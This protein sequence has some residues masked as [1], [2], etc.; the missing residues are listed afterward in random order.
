[1]ARKKQLTVPYRRKGSGNTNYKKRRLLLLAGKPRLVIR[2]SLKNVMCVVA[3]YSAEGDKMM[4]STHSR[5]LKK[6]GWQL[7]ANNTSGAYLTGLLMGVKIKGKKLENLVVDLGLHPCIKGSKITAVIK[8]IVD[9]GI[10]L[11]V[12]KEIL[13]PEERIKGEHI[14]RFAE[15]LKKD[16][17]MYNKQFSDYIKKN[18][19]PVNITTY[20]EQTKNKIMKGTQNA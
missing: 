15:S 5:E 8:G 3:E 18:I 17:T 20:F 13:P 4:L 1:M 12:S 10:T 7:N 19:D 9:A 2:L 16:E 6:Y 11:E 14:A